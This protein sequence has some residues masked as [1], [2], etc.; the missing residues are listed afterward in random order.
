M[1]MSQVLPH[2]LHWFSWVKTINSSYWHLRLFTNWSLPASQTFDV[3][4]LC[5]I[6]VLPLSCSLSPKHTLSVLALLPLVP[7]VSSSHVQVLQV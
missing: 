5:I 1:I 6:P 4:T 2:N 7:L 3:M